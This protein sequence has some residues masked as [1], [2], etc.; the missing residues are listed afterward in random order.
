VEIK[1]TLP[2]WSG[3]PRSPMSVRRS[4]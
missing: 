4:R 2:T 1:K 3:R